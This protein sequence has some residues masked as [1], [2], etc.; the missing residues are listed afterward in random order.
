MGND[1]GN[2]YLPTYRNFQQDEEELKLLLATTYNQLA[3]SLNLKING[4]FDV[5]EFQTGSQYNDPADIRSNRFSFRKMF[6]IDPAALTFNHGITD[7]VL[8]TAIYGTL[9]TAGDFRPLPYVDVVNV[10]NQT[11]ISVTA[12]QVI[13]SNGAGAPAITGGIVVLEYL[14]N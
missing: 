1:I 12:T 2:N 7:A 5:V 9:V 10:I 8:Y 6:Y 11:G 3:T 13:I 4:I 14:K